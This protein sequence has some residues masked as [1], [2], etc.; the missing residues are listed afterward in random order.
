[1]D[2]FFSLIEWMTWRLPR[3]LMAKQSIQ[4]RKM[5]GS[6]KGNAKP[7]MLCNIFWTIPSAFMGIYLPLYMADQGLSKIEIGTVMSAQLV[8]QVFGALVG[9]YLAERFGRLR[10]V[11]LV[12]TCCWPLAYL[13]YSSASGYL[14]F[15]LGSVLVGLVMTLSPAWI[16]LYVEGCPAN[17]R[18]HL[19]GLLQVPWFLGTI[20]SSFSGFMVAQWEVDK[21]C[22]IVFGCATAVTAFSVWLRSRYLK[23]PHSPR[24]PFRPALADVEVLARGHWSAF[25][26]VIKSRKMYLIFA[27]QI[28]TAMF[29]V[30]STTYNN[31]YLVDM[32]G[33][34]LQPAMLAVIPLVG[35]T[36]VLLTT[37]LLVPVVT[38]STIFRWLIISVALMALNILV[39]VMGPAGSLWPVV[40][41]ALV[42]AVGFGLFNPLL[43]GYWS[44]LMTD[45]ERP[46]ILA[47]TAV[48]SMLVTMPAP[49]I[50]GAL[51]TIHPS[52]PMWMLAGIYSLICACFILA[53]KNRRPAP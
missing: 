46:R 8:A 48:A 42:G 29:V 20:L 12:D 16:S 2:E 17:R 13:V 19:F 5:W 22:R 51:F 41:G 3:E 35:G 1:M 39:Y 43:N 49:T 11:N 15:M 25:R 44:N 47:F 32:A 52:G 24:L 18:M 4:F 21:T 37:F 45:R 26:A 36:T 53:S 10:T 50:A 9:G 38:L 31:L 7:L 14:S 27:V 23:D 34:R 33:M 6:L 30:V 40:F 28:L